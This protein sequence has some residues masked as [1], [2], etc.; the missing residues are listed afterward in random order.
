LFRIREIQIFFQY[1]EDHKKESRTPIAPESG[2]GS[3]TETRTIKLRSLDRRTAQVSIAIGV[4][5]ATKEKQNGQ[6]R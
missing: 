2:A 1:L 6:K 3:A 5:T 4:T